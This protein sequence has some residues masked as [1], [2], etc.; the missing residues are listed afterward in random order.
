ME[1]KDFYH[2]D[3]K[4]TKHIFHTI[5][6]CCDSEDKNRKSI[7][8]YKG[9]TLHNF[10]LPKESPRLIVIKCFI[11]FYMEIRPSFILF[12]KICNL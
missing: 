4:V 12:D 8:S 9:L 3:K 1:H 6:N 5:S 10:L 7:P 11:L 2:V